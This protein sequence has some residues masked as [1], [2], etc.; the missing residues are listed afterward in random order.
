MALGE[1][2]NATFERE[3]PYANQ[4]PAD[5]GYRLLALARF[6][7]II[8]YWFPYRDLLEDWDGVLSDFTPRLVA[9]DDWDSYRLEILQ[10]LVQVEDGHVNLWSD[11][12]VR[13]PGGTCTW[14]V[15]TR[16]IEGQ[17]VVSGLLPDYDTGF[18]KG[19]VIENIGGEA[20]ADLIEARRPYY[21][22]SNEAWRLNDIANTMSEGECGLS[23]V[24]VRRGAAL[25]TL[26]PE[27]IDI[28]SSVGAAHYR[29]GKT[30][31][32]LSPEV[33]YL[34]MMN[35]DSNDIPDYLEQAAGTKGLIIDIR[36]YPAEFA[37]FSLGSTSGSPN[38][39]FC[40]RLPLP[41][42][43]HPGL[44]EWV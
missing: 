2:G 8:E 7:N 19:D 12:D 9:A 37:V 27:R 25:Q 44:F 16:M 4:K 40:S 11:L 42:L 20:V 32:L 14:P 23:E 17:V 5:S 3:L 13:P 21:A 18:E 31:E 26:E 36:G 39:A 22:A 35:F 43:S 24:T 28:G 38:N 34:N 10:L 1:V 30:F 6:W 15:A 33:A 41:T 29:L